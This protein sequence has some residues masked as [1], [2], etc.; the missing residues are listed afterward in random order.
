LDLQWPHPIL[1]D[2][3][4]TGITVRFPEQ[5]VLERFAVKAGPKEFAFAKECPKIGIGVDCRVLNV[6]Q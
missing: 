4:I 6:F 5:T 3:H 1:R 2:P